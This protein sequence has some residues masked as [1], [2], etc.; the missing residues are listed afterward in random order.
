MVKIGRQAS[1]QAGKQAD[2]LRR[3]KGGGSYFVGYPPY[4]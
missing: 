2:W 1:R 3:L 4:I